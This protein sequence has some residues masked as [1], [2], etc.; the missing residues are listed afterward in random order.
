MCEKVYK[1][2]KVCKV[3]RKSIGTQIT[4]IK[5]MDTDFRNRLSPQ[6]KNGLSQKESL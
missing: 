4:Q 6:I 1:V 3:E 5:L 2:C